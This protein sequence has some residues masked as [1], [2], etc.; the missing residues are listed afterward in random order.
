MKSLPLI[1]AA[2]VSILLLA[3]CS[4]TPTRDD[5]DAEGMQEE[6]I[7]G[8]DGGVTAG[9]TDGGS[10]DEAALYADKPGLSDSVIY[11]EFDSFAVRSEFRDLL[12]EHARFL[13]DNPQRRVTVEGHTD[14]RGS[15]EYNIALGERRG[16]AVRDMLLINGVAPEQIRV[17]SYGEERPAVDGA[18]ESAWAQNRRAELVYGSF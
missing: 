3:G 7:T 14:E 12:R 8:G 4:S 5:A 11:F 6:R 17:V 13:R 2:A 1:S 16:N 15:R 9:V 18:D 10:L